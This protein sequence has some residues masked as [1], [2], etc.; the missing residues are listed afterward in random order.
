[1]REAPAI[2][3]TASGSSIG[4]LIPARS[5]ATPTARYIAPVSM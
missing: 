5:A 1:M 3:A 2:R 4:S